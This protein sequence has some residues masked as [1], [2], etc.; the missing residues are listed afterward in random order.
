[1]FCRTILFLSAFCISHHQVHAIDGE[2]IFLLDFSHE[3]SEFNS[4]A[5]LTTLLARA[6]LEER[7]PVIATPT[8]F[9]ALN[10]RADRF[11]NVYNGG[12]LTLKQAFGFAQDPK[13][14]NAAQKT[15]LE[16]DDIKKQYAQCVAHFKLCLNAF[17]SLGKSEDPCTDYQKAL[18]TIPNP[19]V[20]SV[21]YI[22]C[23][24]DFVCAQCQ[25]SGTLWRAFRNDDRFVLIIPK[26]YI[27]RQKKGIQQQASLTELAEVWA[28]SIIKKSP[29]E[30]EIA[31]AELSLITGLNMLPHY[32]MFREIPVSALTN[33]D[34]EWLQKKGARTHRQSKDLDVLNLI[35]VF[36][37]IPFVSQKANPLLTQVAELL[38]HWTIFMQGHGSTATTTQKPIIASLPF[39]VFSRFL[40]DL[41]TK[42]ATRLL[43]YKTCYAGGM[44]ERMLSES[45]T[46]KELSYTIVAD[47]IADIQT[48]STFLA[49]LTQAGFT[50]CF[51]PAHARFPLPLESGGF[52][53]FFDL[54][55]AQEQEQ[56]ESFTH[57]LEELLNTAAKLRAQKSTASLA[58]I[59]KLIPPIF[60]PLS[61]P[62][63]E[64]VT[65]TQSP[66]LCAQKVTRFLETFKPAQISQLS[67][68]AYHEQLNQA[69]KNLF[70]EQSAL[71]P[72]TYRIRYPR[73]PWFSPGKSFAETFVL[74]K[75]TRPSS[76][77]RSF[78]YTITYDQQTNRFLVSRKTILLP[79]LIDKKIVIPAST[80]VLIISTEYIE[81]PLVFAGK[82]PAVYSTLSK[83][84]QLKD[85]ASPTTIHVIDHLEAPF[86]IL[87]DLF[88][89]FSLAI[90]SELSSSKFFLIKNAQ[91]GNENYHS[92]LIALE[93][94]EK[95]A[96]LFTLDENGLFLSSSFKDMTSAFTIKSYKPKG[97]AYLLYQKIVKSIKSSLGTAR[98]QQ[99]Y[100][101]YGL[102]EAPDYDYLLKFLPNKKALLATYDRKK[103]QGEPLAEWLL[104][105]TPQ[106]RLFIRILRP[107]QNISQQ[108]SSKLG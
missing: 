94:S 25:L 79:A 58:D 5:P 65:C 98:T 104:N 13:I 96:T 81:S 101:E 106:Q 91:L 36:A 52:S 66:D 83:P 100:Q 97:D 61:I 28:T 64:F 8:L 84:L 57:I 37:P 92:V 76:F 27:A 85:L 20:N 62:L 93:A 45:L 10:A 67:Q 63:K 24:R 4:N 50:Q 51:F 30:S 12:T 31:Q 42:I 99:Y 2:I 103:A 56:R 88:A 15:S 9:E 22:E 95:T 46:Q 73:S 43:F 108:L 34:F 77:R 11:L 89:G 90:F 26:T 29:S 75:Q 107:E 68:S 87:D 40:D 39:E 78:D 55:T 41:D 16:F 17:A 102:L 6:I 59:E 32:G 38:P 35:E 72:G 1:M 74:T 49:P 54:I 7:C 23:M 53:R 105:L 86:V 44:T 3:E 47:G 82:M 48:Y 60:A 69:I 33:K 80:D 14:L 70:G 18:K 71:K 21:L 19:A